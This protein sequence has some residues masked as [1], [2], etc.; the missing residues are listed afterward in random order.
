MIQVIINMAYSWSG[1]GR[2]LSK[3]ALIGFFA[4]ASCASKDNQLKTI[5]T[6][7]DSKGSTG[8]AVVG[9][10]SEGQAILQQE[11][12]L[13]SEIR[14]AQHVNENLRMNIRSEFYHLKECW[15][16]RAR[17]TTKEMPELSEFEDSEAGATTTE[18][19]G[20]V[21]QDVK[22]VRKEDAIA[23]LRAE[24]RTQEGLR[25]HLSNTKKQREKCEFEA[26]R[27]SDTTA[28]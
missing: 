13:S 25:A 20:L 17:T 18:E 28:Q 9:V 27:D 4:L 2:G 26:Q 7:L 15:K 23:R 24:K 22:V 6:T 12:Q 1:L 5:D 8:T 16:N 3:F 19:V 11:T 10:N 21:G 14:T